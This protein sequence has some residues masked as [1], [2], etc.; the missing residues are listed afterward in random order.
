MS[1]FEAEQK[2]R[3]RRAR[4]NNAFEYNT[5]SGASIGSVLLFFTTQGTKLSLVENVDPQSSKHCLDA[6]AQVAFVTVGLVTGAHLQ[7]MQIKS[8]RYL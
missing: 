4:G 1:V 2:C 7:R 8:T 3:N 5:C 6:A